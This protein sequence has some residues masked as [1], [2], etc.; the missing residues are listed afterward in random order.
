MTVCSCSPTAVN[1]LKDNIFNLLFIKFV[2]VLILLI[3]LVRTFHVHAIGRIISIVSLDRTT[4]CNSKIIKAVV[5]LD[6]QTLHD[7]ICVAIV[8]SQKKLFN[9]DC[10]LDSIS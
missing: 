6:T 5:P 4:T 2:L 3:F 10:E 7:L 1:A 9:V 8:S